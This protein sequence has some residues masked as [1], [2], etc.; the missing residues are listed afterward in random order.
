MTTARSAFRLCLVLLFVF[1]ALASPRG[2]WAQF[3]P[4]FYRGVEN[5]TGNVFLF[6]LETPLRQADG[7]PLI[8]GTIF[9]LE[10]GTYRIVA[11]R[12][13]RGGLNIYYSYLCTALNQ[14]AAAQIL[15]SP[16][17]AFVTHPGGLFINTELI[18]SSDCCQ[19]D[20]LSEESLSYSCGQGH[21]GLLHRLRP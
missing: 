12:T 21:D 5:E 6:R 4:G 20:Q 14:A 10:A 3:T 17:S 16:S 9:N 15:A 1:S 11:G 19:V 13:D 8:V 2:A 7:T 18:N